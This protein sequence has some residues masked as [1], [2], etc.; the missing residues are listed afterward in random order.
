MKLTTNTSKVYSLLNETRGGKESLFNL[1][2]VSFMSILRKKT[3]GCL[4]RGIYNYL[5]V[6]RHT[7]KNLMSVKSMQSLTKLTMPICEISLLYLVA[8]EGFPL[9]SSMHCGNSFGHSIVI[10]CYNN[11]SI[12]IRI[13]VTQWRCPAGHARLDGKLP[14]EMLSTYQ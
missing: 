9:D 2:A 13:F 7:W 5:F 1:L 6:E 4:F 8:F 3:Q 14:R 12:N 11:D 10:L